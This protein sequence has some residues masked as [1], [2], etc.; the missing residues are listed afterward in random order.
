MRKN[1]TDILVLHHAHK[2]RYSYSA[3]LGFT[4]AVCVFWNMHGNY[5]AKRKILS[6]SRFEHQPVCAFNVGLL[7]SVFDLMT[8]ANSYNWPNHAPFEFIQLHLI[9]LL[10]SLRFETRSLLS[11]TLEICPC[12]GCNA[13]VCCYL[14][15]PFI[16]QTIVTNY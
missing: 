3:F 15:Q 14:H 16:S 12:A 4:E 7:R 9:I 1:E 13:F 8:I 5:P 6:Q 11:S 10:A 2:L